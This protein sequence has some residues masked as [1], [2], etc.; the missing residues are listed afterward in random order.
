M[1]INEKGPSFAEKNYVIILRNNAAIEV[2]CTD[3][4]TSDQWVQFKNEIGV[5]VMAVPIDL[6][7]MITTPDRFAAFQRAAEDERARQAA[8]GV[9]PSATLDPAISIV[10]P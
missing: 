7:L 1:G 2:T 3:V 10:K 4:Y 5:L 9:A 8:A 6:I